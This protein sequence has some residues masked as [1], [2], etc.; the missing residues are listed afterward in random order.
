MKNKVQSN[1]NYANNKYIEECLSGYPKYKYLDQWLIRNSKYLKNSRIS[2][3]K[4]SNQKKYKRGSIVFVD[5][6]VNIGS[7]FSNK[8]FAVVLNKNDSIRNNVLTVVPITSHENRF[9]V[10]I[11]SL[12]AIK[13][14]E[15]LI[16]RNI[17]L[18]KI[19]ASIILKKNIDISE[20]KSFNDIT[21]N[22]LNSIIN[23]ITIEECDDILK[24]NNIDI[25]NKE[26]LKKYAQNIIQKIKLDEEIK[27]FYNKYDKISYAKCLDI[28]T[29]SKDRIQLLNRLDPVGEIVASNETMNLIDKAI[30]KNFTL[31]NN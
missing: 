20:E 4:N 10:K 3:Q 14:R 26:S 5:F 7:E 21:R 12:I 15:I 18:L 25:H 13:S 9:T 19:G 6:G 31:N 23:E 30:I 17:E 27:A 11:D 1:C 24:K 16:N 29:I 22:L 8:H 2:S 28:Q